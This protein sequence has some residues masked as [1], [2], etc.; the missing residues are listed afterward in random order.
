MI[1]DEISEISDRRFYC[2]DEVDFTVF[3]KSF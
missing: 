2:F 1:E 3:R